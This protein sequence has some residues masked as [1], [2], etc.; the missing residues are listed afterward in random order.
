MSNLSLNEAE[1]RALCDAA[2]RPGGALD[3]VDRRTRISLIA[4]GY[5]TPVIDWQERPWGCE[6]L[7]TPVV[8]ATHLTSLGRSAELAERTA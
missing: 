1:R 4:R 6:V 3:G 7:L 2:A 5:A 8:T